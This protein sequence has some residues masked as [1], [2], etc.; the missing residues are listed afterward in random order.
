[1]GIGLTREEYEAEHAEKD[2]RIEELEI[3]LEEKIDKEI[4]ALKQHHSLLLDFLDQ[5]AWWTDFAADK[6]AEYEKEKQ[7]GRE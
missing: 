1:M 5:Y 3:T 4:E 2:K 6:W 7:E